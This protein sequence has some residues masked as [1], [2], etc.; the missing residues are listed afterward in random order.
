MDKS[1]DRL[2]ESEAVRRYGLARA[3]IANGVIATFVHFGTEETRVVSGDRSQ[4]ACPL[5]LSIGYGQIARSCFRRALPT[6]ASLEN[7]IAI[8]EDEL[9]KFRTAI[10]R[11]SELFAADDMVHRIAHIAGNQ[12]DG[13]LSIEAVETIF[14]RLAAI[15]LGRPAAQDAI[16]TDQ[17]FAAALTILRELMHHFGYRSI[18]VLSLG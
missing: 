18:A 4:S 14:E 10:P 5:V 13:K 3:E 7:A 1:D 11:N 16:P 12:G 2:T 6:P 9:M 15:A 17:E 8:V